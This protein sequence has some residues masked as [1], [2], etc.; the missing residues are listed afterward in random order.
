[1]ENPIPHHNAPVL[2][3]HRQVGPVD[4]SLDTATDDSVMPDRILLGECRP[5][6]PEKA[7]LAALEQ[8]EV[9]SEM[10]AL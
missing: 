8:A 5:N 3:D 4:S 10:W 1:L 2:E 7:S 6:K 9:L